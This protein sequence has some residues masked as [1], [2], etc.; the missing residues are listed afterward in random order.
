LAGIDRKASSCGRD[1]SQ[2][3]ANFEGIDDRGREVLTFIP[4]ECVH[5]DNLAVL[6]SD[7]AMRRVGELIAAYHRAQAGYVS[8]PDAAWRT[9]GRDPTGSIEV[10]AHNDLAPWNLIAGSSGWVFID[11][12]LAAPGRRMWDLAWAVHSFVGLWPDSTLTDDE[13]VRRIAAFCDGAEVDTRDRPYLL[14]VVIE[15][16]RHHSEFLRSKA[17]DGNAEY[18]RLVAD[19]HA[20][21]WGQGSDHVAAN[22]DRWSGA[23]QV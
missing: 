13:T 22:R 3:R 6:N 15:R 10:I 20:D 11:W 14:E 16:T 12:D 4:G 17:R 23:L 7:S 18:R 9:E 8:L 5:P 2:R 19:G 1:H 21:A